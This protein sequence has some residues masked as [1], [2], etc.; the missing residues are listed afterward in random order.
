V[1]RDRAHRAAP[2]ADPAR[3]GG[4]G[5]LSAA[6]C[7]GEATG[8]NRFKSKARSPAGTGPDPFPGMERRHAVPSQQTPSSYK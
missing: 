6:K 8:A 2:G 7:V 5:A 1:R 3:L 4:C